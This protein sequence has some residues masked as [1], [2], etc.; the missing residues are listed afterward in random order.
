MDTEP[1]T[2][3][4][5]VRAHASVSGPREHAIEAV[6]ELV[7]RGIVADYE[8]HAWP[9][10]VDLTVPCDVTRRYREFEAWAERAGVTLEPAFSRRDEDNVITGEHTETLVTPLVCTAVRRGDELVAVLPCCR[11]E[12]DHVSVLSYLSALDEG[13]DPLGEGKLPPATVA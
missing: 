1:L 5:Y 9:S 2:V 13:N 7:A 10:A 4:L 12:D 6:D 11:G 8:V 3:D